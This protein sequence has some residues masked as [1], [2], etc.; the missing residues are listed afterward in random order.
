MAKTTTPQQHDMLHLHWPNDCCLCTREQRIT[1]LEEALLDANERID[2]WDQLW[3]GI[4]YGGIYDLDGAKG[5]AEVALAEV[6]C[7]HQW[8]PLPYWDNDQEPWEQCSRCKVNR[9]ARV[10]LGSKKI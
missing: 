2:R 1:E 10:V 3:L 9:P 7:E 4:L 6:D 8:G 5:M